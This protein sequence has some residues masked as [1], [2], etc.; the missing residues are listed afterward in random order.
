MMIGLAAMNAQRNLLLLVFGIIMGAV[1]CSG[2]V[3]SLRHL[4]VSRSAPQVVMEGRRFTIRHHVRNLSRWRGAFGLE[5]VELADPDWIEG[6]P[7]SLVLSVQPQQESSARA[8]AVCQRRGRLKLPKLRIGT[9]FPFGLLVKYATVVIPQEIISLPAVGR[10]VSEDIW[11]DINEMGG[12]AGQSAASGGDE[13]LAGIRDYRPGD[14]PR[15]IHW[16]RSARTGNLVVREMERPKAARAVVIL[17]TQRSR[18]DAGSPETIELAIRFAA[19]LICDGLSRGFQVGLVCSGDSVVAIPP[20]GG[21]EHSL[22]LLRELALL[23][24]N[25]DASLEESVMPASFAGEW[26]GRCVLIT[27]RAGSDVEQVSN[28][29]TKTVGATNVVSLKDA[30]ISR[31]YRDQETNGRGEDRSRPDLKGAPNVAEVSA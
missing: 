20:A 22:P 19:T 16:R 21:E 2:L 4:Q 11:P 9:R 13:D 17:D 25:S 24:E 31:W 27:S 10:I 23:E 18:G 6:Y 28:R 8:H 15:Q 7:E 12:S 29:L 30:D 26:K 3:G 5:L 14:N 1:F